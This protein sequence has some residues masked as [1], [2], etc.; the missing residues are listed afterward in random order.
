VLL[1]NA[2]RTA[3]FRHERDELALM[4]RPSPVRPHFLEVDV[5]ACVK[6]WNIAASLSRRN[7]V[8]GLGYLEPDDAFSC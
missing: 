4:A 7:G 3:V 6:G 1:Q 8:T 2:R 5:S